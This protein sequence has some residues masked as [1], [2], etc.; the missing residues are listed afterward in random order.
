VQMLVIS[1]SI[2]GK[3]W[4]DIYDTVG[5]LLIR[6]VSKTGLAWVFNVLQARGEMYVG[7][8]Q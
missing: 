1:D 3:H 4:A 2:L 7:F 5:C 8:H 6:D